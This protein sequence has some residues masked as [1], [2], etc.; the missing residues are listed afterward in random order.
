MSKKD[1][2]LE[3]IILAYLDQ[4]SPIGSSELNHRMKEDIPAST[5]RVYFKK[6]ST[7][8]AIT[9]L[10]ISSGRIPTVLAM[11]NFWKKNLLFDK[12]IE[13]NDF[14]NLE[15]IVKEF[16]IYCMIYSSNNKNLKEVINHNNRFIIL[17]FDED[18][19]VLKYSS[20]IF[21]ILSSLKSI[22][23]EDLEKASIQIGFSELRDKIKGLKHSKIEFLANEV[24]ACEIFKNDRIRNLLDPSIERYF[25]DYL[26][27]SPLFNDGFMGVK[28]KI[29]FKDKE[30]TM[31]CAGSV[32]KNFKKFFNTILEEI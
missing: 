12:L 15:E 9:Q 18:E 6:L 30:A 11:K 13:I 25:S 17:V 29:N 24:V 7:E 3:S 1:I 10:H 2:I 26:M 28:T 5:I 16:G 4:N 19:I 22:D 20:K 31:I 23:I 8:G 27:F 21:E 32:Y 14:S